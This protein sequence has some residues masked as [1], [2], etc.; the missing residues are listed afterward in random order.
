MRAAGPAERE[1]AAFA[2]RIFALIHKAQ[3][4][5]IYTSCG[6]S[7]AAG[8]INIDIAPMLRPEDKLRSWWAVARCCSIKRTS[9]CC[10]CAESTRGRGTIAIRCLA[11]FMPTC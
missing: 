5:G 4:V 10:P 2:E 11:S 6:T 3:P 8:F 9:R 1:M 7:P